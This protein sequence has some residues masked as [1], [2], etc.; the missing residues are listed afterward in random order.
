MAGWQIVA[1]C[2]P[3]AGV[4]GWLYWLGGG[5][6]PTA[7]A[8]WLAPLP[9]LLLAP[10]VPWAAAVA[11]AAAAWLVGELRAWSYQTGDLGNPRV[12]VAARMIGDAAGV[13][14]IVGLA[15]GFMVHGRPGLAVLAVPVAWVAMEFLVSLGSA[16]GAWWSLAYTQADVPAVT[17]IASVTGPWGV[18]ALVTLAPAA[19]AATA[20]P[21]GTRSERVA[22]L[23]AAAAVLILVPGLGIA[24]VRRAG[25]AEKLH[26]G[27]ALVT[28]SGPAVPVGSPEG[29]ALVSRYAELLQRLAGSGARVVVLPEATL[30]VDDDHG[31]AELRPISQ[32]AA[33]RRVEVVVGAVRRGGPDPA[34]L[35]LAFPPDGAPPAVYR[36]QHLIPGLEAAYRPGRQ[37]RYAADPR[38]GLIICKD[39]DF[40]ALTRSY[41]RGG[42]RLLLAP[43]WDFGR[44]GWLHSRMAML[45]G[46]ES[47]LAVARV[48]RDG[49]LT[50]HDA[51]GR[52]LVDTEPATD[53]TADVEVPLFDTSTP[54]QRLGD[55]FAW[56]CVAATVILAT[57]PI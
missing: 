12:R 44:D 16:H 25:P 41:R 15:R 43:A 35:A 7:A 54:Y 1:V 19:V 17:Q 40:P 37:L 30:A 33:A 31:E 27:L 56:C 28:Q 52:T 2:L 18:S 22:V 47:G 23:V 9:L 13:G 24:R 26:V 50:V 42:A 11:V 14:A 21:A 48:A 51:Y 53:T 39:L 32:L 38:L 8:V 5:L 57:T 10:R 36:K 4:S 49:R 3:V 45:R 46:I 29:A 20:A 55:A 34:N 6:R